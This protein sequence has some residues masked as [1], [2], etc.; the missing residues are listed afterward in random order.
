VTGT[1]TIHSFTI[2][3]QTTAPG[4]SDETPYVVAYVQVTEDSTCILLANLLVHEDR[5]DSINVGAPVRVVFENRHD[6][7]VPQFELVM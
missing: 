1:G 5:F 2:V 4:F 7:T 3:R 6:V